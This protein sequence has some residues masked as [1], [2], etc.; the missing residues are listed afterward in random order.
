MTSL[1]LA[2]K[3]RLNFLTAVNTLNYK[4]RNESAMRINLRTLYPTYFRLTVTF[5]AVSAATNV[6]C[7]QNMMPDCAGDQICNSMYE[8]AREQSSLGNLGEASRLYKLAFQIIPDPRLLF[9][10]GRLLHR[11][12]SMDDARWYYQKFVDSDIDDLE[13]K[14]KARGYLSALPAVEQKPAASALSLP[15]VTAAP[16]SSPASSTTPVVPLRTLR[17][18]RPAFPVGAGALFAA[19]GAS[20]LTGVVCG[21]LALS[22]EKAIVSTNAPYDPQLWQRGTMLSRAAISLDVLGGTML[23]GGVI[24]SAVWKVKAFRVAPGTGDKS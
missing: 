6:A 17:D 8:R 15:I 3:S 20:L 18:R 12:G 19:G 4:L 21:S 1:I 11:Q 16:S 2:P 10:I 5:L 14:E 7:A 22:A 24:W 9:S 23:L 13:Q